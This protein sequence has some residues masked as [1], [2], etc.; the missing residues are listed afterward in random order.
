MPGCPRPRGARRI[1]ALLGGAVL[2]AV[3]LS[4]CVAGGWRSDRR[5]DA[6]EDF[7]VLGKLAVRGGR[8]SFSARFSWQQTADR[9]ALELWGP[10]GQGRRRLRGTADEL[11]V[12]N[13]AGQVLAEGGSREVLERSVG[14]ALPLQS[15]RFWIQGLADPALPVRAPVRDPLTRA[16]RS[17]EQAGWAVAVT[18]RLDGAGMEPDRPRKIIANGMGYEIRLALNRW[19]VPDA[20]F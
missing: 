7:A 3:A 15:L 4:G 13:G 8:D 20:A 18:E 19:G 2:L 6:G 10:F 11:V 12:L 1:V 5:G 9:F 17:F 16:L 14:F